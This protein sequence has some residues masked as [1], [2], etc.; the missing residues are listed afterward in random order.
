[1]L[2]NMPCVICRDFY[3]AADLQ[4]VIFVGKTEEVCMS[5]LETNFVEVYIDSDTSTFLHKSN[6]NICVYEGE[7]FLYK[8]LQNRGLELDRD[9]DIIQTIIKDQ[10]DR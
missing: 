10:E 3:K 2:C 7:Y 6:P 9:G 4:S 5:C 1:M 8:T